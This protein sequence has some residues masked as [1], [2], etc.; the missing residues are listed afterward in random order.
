M[1]NN[2]KNMLDEYFDYLVNQE[3]KKTS[4][5]TVSRD[6]KIKRVTSN[7]A[8]K[9]A[10]DENDAMYKQYKKHKD[11]YKKYQEKIVKKYGP[12]VRSQAR[13]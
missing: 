13:R 1:S 6:E 5:R 9:K 3:A 11:L 2:F 7:L 12:K 10:K 4:R 8:I